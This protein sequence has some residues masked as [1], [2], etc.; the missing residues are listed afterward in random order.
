MLEERRQRVREDAVEAGWWELRL[1]SIVQ[2]IYAK[3]TSSEH[4]APVFRWPF[5]LAR[6]GSTSGP[7][8]SQQAPREL[9]EVRVLRTHP[10]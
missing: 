3:I 10:G 7:A 8:M 2:Q 9:K 5:A 6:S 1:N 4:I